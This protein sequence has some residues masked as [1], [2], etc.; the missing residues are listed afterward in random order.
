MEKENKRDVIIGVAV[1]AMLAPVMIAV[2]AGTEIKYG[3]YYWQYH[4]SSQS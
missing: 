4:S 3:T 1:A 2:T